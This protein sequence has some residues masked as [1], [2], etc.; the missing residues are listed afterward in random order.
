[1]ERTHISAIERAVRTPSL[2]T[3]FKLAEALD[4]KPSEVVRLIEEKK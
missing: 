3:L 2:S 4:K 1:M